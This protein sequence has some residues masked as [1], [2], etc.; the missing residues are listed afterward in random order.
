MVTE[1]LASSRPSFLALRYKVLFAHR[2][3][4]E[5]KLQNRRKFF[6]FTGKQRQ[7]QGECESRV[8]GG[9][10][11]S[12]ASRERSA[13]GLALLSARSPSIIS[14]TCPK[15]RRNAHLSTLRYEVLLASYEKTK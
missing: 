7:T 8:S 5:A 14:T 12:N 15:G 3:I 13:R 11:K 2:K 6:R 9:A 1:K 10:R 4:Y